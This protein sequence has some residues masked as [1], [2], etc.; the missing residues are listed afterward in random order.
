MDATSRF[1]HRRSARFDQ[2]Q[3]WRSSVRKRT[4]RSLCAAYLRGMLHK[5]ITS[6]HH[7]LIRRCKEK[8]ASR[9]ESAETHDAIDKG[10]PLFLQQLATTL[11]AEQLA[12]TRSV[13]HPQP[14][15][16]DLEIG[17]SA[18]LHGAEMLRLGFTVDQVVHEYGAVCQ[19]V[20][21]LAVAEQVNISTDEFRTL[22]RCLDNAIADA[23]R[24]FGMTRQVHIDDQAEDLHIRL[25]AF[26]DEYVRLVDVAAHA[27]AA[28]K[29]GDVGLNGA[30]GSLLAHTLTE[31][32]FLAERTLPAICLA[33][34]PTTLPNK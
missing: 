28:I 23:V 31:L 4:Y 25:G 12:P 3:Q 7:E 27:F 30:T 34:A 18:A 33:S 16:P 17:R 19:S 32:R 11:R 24:S 29:T 2:L 14:N 20:T 5:F 26:T 21:D 15:L 13:E 6:Q 10:I 8:A 22:N 9:F 1:K